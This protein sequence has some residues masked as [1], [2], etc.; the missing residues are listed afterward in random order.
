VGF[1]LTKTRVVLCPRCP[2]IDTVLPMNRVLVRIH[3]FTSLDSAPRH[4]SGVRSRQPWH[5]MA[6]NADGW[7]RHWPVTCLI[8]SPP[9]S[10]D[11]GVTGTER[12]RDADGAECSSND[13]CG[14]ILLPHSAELHRSK[15]SLITCFTNI[16][17]SHTQSSTKSLS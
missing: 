8:T 6:H 2:S 15:P 12:I 3:D 4:P 10:S 17:C 5:K 14:R 7:D 16:R 9:C 11:D 1:C 13:A